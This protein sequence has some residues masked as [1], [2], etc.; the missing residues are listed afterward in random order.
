M[1]KPLLAALSLMMLV[2]ACGTR[3]NPFNW[4]R[5]SEPAAAAAPVVLK[6]E[7]PRLLAEQITTLKVEPMPGGAIVR[8][9]ALPPTQGW[10]SADLVAV[11]DASADG[12]L[13]YDFR[14]FPPLEQMAASTPRSRQITAA[15]FLSDIQLSTVRSITVRGSSNGLSSRR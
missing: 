3:L 7:D 13:V 6:A 15:V 4:F 2:S 1:K 5:A 12:Q 9:T 14:L 8:A 10:W 11:E